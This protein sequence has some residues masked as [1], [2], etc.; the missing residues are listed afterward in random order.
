MP[1]FSPSLPHA[2]GLWFSGARG[3]HLSFRGSLKARNGS[4]PE[5]QL[6]VCPSP[7]WHRPGPRPRSWS[8]RCRKAR[9]APW[10]PRLGRSENRWFFSSP[11]GFD[12]SR[13]A[14]QAHASSDGS[15]ARSGR[16]G[17]RFPSGTILRLALRSTSRRG[18]AQRADPGCFNF[19]EQCYIC[20]SLAVPCRASFAFAQDWAVSSSR[21]ELLAGCAWNEFL[22][23]RG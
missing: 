6:R 16:A 17:L 3:W 1:S 5:R 8:W 11:G 13:G 21:E 2:H 9:K 18:L 23:D 22:K 15:R 10:P 20:C 19:T 12:R 4:S 14:Q 7:A